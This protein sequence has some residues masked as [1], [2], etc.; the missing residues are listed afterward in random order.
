MLEH[1]TQYHSE[2]LQALL[3]CV[4]PNRSLGNKWLLTRRLRLWGGCLLFKIIFGSKIIVLA[5]KSIMMHY[6]Q[7]QWFQI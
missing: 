3:Y 4:Y 6:C 5:N 2:K 1:Y 7:Y